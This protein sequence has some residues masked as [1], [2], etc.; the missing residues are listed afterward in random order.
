MIYIAPISGLV[1]GAKI[2]KEFGTAK[3]LM[4]NVAIW[5]KAEKRVFFCEKSGGKVWWIRIFFVTL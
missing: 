5:Q 3:N 4:K 2:I 1:C